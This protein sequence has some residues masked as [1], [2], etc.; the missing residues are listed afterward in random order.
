MHPTL[1]HLFGVQITTYGLMMAMAFA[2]L[3]LCSVHRGQKL[4]YT[5]D[6]IINLITVIVVSAFVFARLLHV[7]VEWKYYS[8]NP[9][10]ILLSRDGFVFLGGF[11][12]AVVVAVWFT[13]KAGQSV[14]GVADL[15]APYLALAQGIGRIGCFLYGCCFGKICS[16]YCGVHFPVDS[17]AYNFQ[18]NEGLIGSDAV[19]SLPVHPT[20]LYL[21]LFDF[22]HFAILLLIRR[23]HTFRGQLAMCYLMIYSV[24]RFG[25]EFFR[26][27]AYRGVYG[28]LSTSQILGLL[29]FLAGL[30]GFL[31]LRKRNIPP[32]QVIE[33]TESNRRDP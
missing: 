9:S 26:G 17:P 8:Q 23:R 32:E 25:V 24:G 3:W 13:R 12:G 21:S 30:I 5:Q 31:L 28:F 2:A 6:F 15:F 22:I 16:G 27:D 33:P 19:S 20:Q 7:I 1:F 11:I 18:F 29:L 14:L 4:G 10:A